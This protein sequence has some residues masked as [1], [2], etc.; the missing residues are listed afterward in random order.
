M[1]GQMPVDQP[2][3]LLGFSQGAVIRRPRDIAS[4]PIGNGRRDPVDDRNWCCGVTLIRRR[5]AASRR[6]ETRN[7][8]P[9]RRARA[10]EGDPARGASVLVRARSDQPGFGARPPGGFAPL[11]DKTIRDT[12][13]H[14]ET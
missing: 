9:N 12:G 2:T 14:R 13:V 7:L 10:A 4:D 6:W 8:G 1:K 3:C 11:K 5:P